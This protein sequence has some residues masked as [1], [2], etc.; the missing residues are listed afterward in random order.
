MASFRINPAL[1]VPREMRR[2][3]L[4]QVELAEAALQHAGG[5]DRERRARG[6]HDFRKAGKRI[7]AGLQL[8]R[9][10]GDDV[11]V[12][13]ASHGFREAARA[14][15]GLRDRDAL[16]L[17]LGEEAKS[18]PAAD[19]GSSLEAWR[20]LLLPPPPARNAGRAD[21]LAEEIAARLRVIRTRWQRAHLER[22]DV[23]RLAAALRRSWA[24]ARRRFHGEWNPASAEWIH[25]TR[26][27]TQR[28]LHQVTLVEWWVGAAWTRMRRDLERTAERLGEA[29]DCG[30]LVDRAESL[31][32]GPE[33]RLEWLRKRLCGRRDA[34]LAECRR[35]GRAALR[36][37]PAEVEK[38]VLRP[39]R[40][41][42]KTVRKPR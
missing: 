27:R 26:K 9:R 38:A 18:L 34:A 39:A 13:L 6:I 25:E 37:R 19:R 36:R 23:N 29:R 31:R 21:R 30:L 40:R 20:M 24:R 16:D 14:L 41:P 42:R 12:T 17:I 4:E 22:M 5:H 28:V 33:S 7:R 3:I 11:T 10:A 1:P 2:A 15:S 35:L 8:L 32:A